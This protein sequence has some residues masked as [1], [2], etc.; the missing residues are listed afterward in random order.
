MAAYVT[1]AEIEKYMGLTI[2]S[3]LSSFITTLISAVEDY[4]ENYCGGGI[5][6]KRW[7]NDSDTP[8]DRYYDGKGLTKIRIDDIR[9]CTALVVD[10]VALT[11]DT[12]FYMYPLN[13]VADGKPYEWIEL[14]QPETRLTTY[15]N[16]RM[17]ITSPYTFLNR[18]K[19]LKVTGKWGYSTTP[20]D[21]IK[22][23]ALK[24]IGGV[25][26][27]NVGDDDV[28]ELTQQS[29]GEYSVSFT[30]LKEIAHSLGVE[31]L[32]NQYKRKANT[33]PAG[34]RTIS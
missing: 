12:D 20:P 4:I 28:K 23:A 14:I 29:L 5:V 3:N 10:N 18:Q 9:D 22:L 30:K 2:A 6:A 1:Q 25:I 31:D 24:L 19:N 11:E 13:A 17:D 15:T 21:A 34:V 33:P 27:E 7:F 16:S 32:L 26:K 8:S